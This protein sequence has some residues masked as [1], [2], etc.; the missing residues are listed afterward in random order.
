MEYK[1]TKLVNFLRTFSEEEFTEFEEFLESSYQK[2]GRNLLPFL[3]LLKRFHPGFTSN[4]LTEEYI[5]RN[6]KPGAAYSDKKSQNIIRTLSSSLLKAVEDFLFISRLKTDEIQKNRILLEEILK[7]NI[8]K[9]FGQYLER[10][11]VS[12]DKDDMNFDA[13]LQEWYNLEKL[14]SGYHSAVFE[15]NKFFEHNSKAFGYLSISFWLELLNIAKLN[16]LSLDNRRVNIENEMVNVFLESADFE[17]VIN[18]FKG[19]KYYTNLC[20]NYYIYR[21]LAGK[22]DFSFYEKAKKIFYDNRD[23]ISRHDKN[24]FYSDLINFLQYGP[25]YNRSDQKAEHLSVIKSCLEDKGYKLND[26]DFMHPNFYRN[27]ILLA[28]SMNEHKWAEEFI[29]KFSDELNP[30]IRDNMKHYSGALI[31]YSKGEFEKALTE[32]S[33]IRYEQAFFGTDIKVLMLRIFYELDLFE[34]ALYLIDAFKHYIKTSPNLSKDF[35][36]AHNNYLNYYKKLMKLKS[37]DGKKRID[38]INYLQKKINEEKFI[39]Q[40]RWLGEKLG[41]LDQ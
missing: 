33:K 18:L 28:E 30:E 32:I 15:M 10:A 27:A 14:N 19:H 25:I 40:R 3:K 24:Y 34:Q 9:Y 8:H 5:F 35:T 21:S 20:F 39:I 37:E 17:K 26:A 13:R 4:E 11:S 6:L 41:E 1:N 7:R 16:L 38:E 36:E 12:L 29:E 22:K 2:A 23:S 31:N